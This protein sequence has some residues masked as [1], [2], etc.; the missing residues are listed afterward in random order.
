M[1]DLQH[2]N[3]NAL[4]VHKLNGNA[5]ERSVFEVKLEEIPEDDGPVTVRHSAAQVKVLASTKTISGK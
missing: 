1:R 3:A 4:A 2:A 5:Y